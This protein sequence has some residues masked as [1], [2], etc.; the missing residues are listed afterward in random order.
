[1]AII[2]LESLTVKEHKRLSKL[3]KA[4]KTSGCTMTIMVDDDLSKEAS[5]DGK[6]Y[7]TLNRGIL[8][9]REQ[10]FKIV[11]FLNI[12]HELA[13]NPECPE[14]YVILN[15]GE[16]FFHRFHDTCFRN[17]R[18]FFYNMEKA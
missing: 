7:I 12:M 4:L 16:P 5:T 8:N 14:E 11:A 17:A 9:L 2:P 13:H 3:Q 18:P 10:S 1:M 6:T 15:H